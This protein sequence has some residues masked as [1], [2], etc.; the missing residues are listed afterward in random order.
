MVKKPRCWPFCII[1]PHFP[2]EFTKNFGVKAVMKTSVLLTWEV[3]ETYNSQA[4]FK[5]KTIL[6]FIC[7]AA[8]AQEHTHCPTDITLVLPHH[9]MNIR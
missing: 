8:P 7:T 6:R 1:Y 5:V 2:S 9:I 3:P 4:P